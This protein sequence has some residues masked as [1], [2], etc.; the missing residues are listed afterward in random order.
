MLQA[1]SEMG[2]I[3]P[4]GPVSLTPWPM[5]RVGHPLCGRRETSARHESGGAAPVSGLAANPSGQLS[6]ALTSAALME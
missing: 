6:P 2:I 1:V 4:G 5:M 3:L